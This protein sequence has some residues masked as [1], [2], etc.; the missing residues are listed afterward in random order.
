MTGKDQLR[1]GLPRQRGGEPWPLEP[2]RR[3]RRR[4]AGDEPRTSSSTPS[5]E[6]PAPRISV[7]PVATRVNTLRRGL[8][9]SPGGEAWPLPVAGP[10]TARTEDSV[11]ADPGGPGA[12]SLPPGPQTI[13]AA[14]AGE[15]TAPL[16]LEPANLDGPLRRG[17]PRTPGGKPPSAGDAGSALRV[18]G[19]EVPRS[20]PEP[21]DRVAPQGVAFP[22]DQPDGSLNGP[23]VPT[24]DLAHPP[25]RTGTFGRR[26]RPALVAAVAAA[27]ILAAVAARLLR[28]F[29]P[30]QHFLADY[31]GQY[32][33]PASAAVGLPEW[34]GWQHFLNVFLMVLIIRSGLQVRRQKRPPAYW[35]PRARPERK[36]SLTLW[37][38][39]GLDLLWLLNGVTFVVLL[40]ATGQWMRIVPTSW[41]VFPN[42]VS[43][44]LQYASLDWPTENGWA[45]YNSLQELAYFV[46]VF[47]AAPLAAATGLRMSGLWPKSPRLGRAYPVEW[48]R[49]L[50]LP[51]MLYFVV[52]IA[53]HVALV[54]ST[55]ALRNLNHIYASRDDSTWAGFWIF[56]ASV[57]AI[58]AGWIAA[59]PLV[60]APIA[61]I[62]GRVTAR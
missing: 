5:T 12:A 15:S 14:A 22:A 27:V 53:V 24:A 49:A 57:I 3:P 44:A 31:P 11:L 19:A 16:E 26:A 46:T 33:L 2:D 20:A 35:S 45:N 18:A 34:V 62:F 23:A 4:A 29:D 21:D 28:S 36:I 39:Q 50:H 9:R 48:A 58:A 41:S 10:G 7:E 25:A 13:E 32:P 30:V 6:M 61:R 38:H 55:G 43:A 17:L 52:F 54:L 1:R 51:V 60:I 56:V 8:P 47:I 42:A 37:F 59:R 40:A